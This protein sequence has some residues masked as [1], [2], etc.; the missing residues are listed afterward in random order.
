MKIDDQIQKYLL[1]LAYILITVVRGTQCKSNIIEERNRLE[2]LD[3]ESKNLKSKDLQGTG[4]VTKPKLSGKT[5]LI[6]YRHTKVS[7]R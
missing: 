4:W 7:G 5:E 2:D 3:T 6:F 1:I